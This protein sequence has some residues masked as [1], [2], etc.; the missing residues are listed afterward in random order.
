MKKSWVFIIFLI[1]ILVVVKLF[2]FPTPDKTAQSGKPG[3]GK[4]QKMSV[5]GYLVQPS[6]LDNL[7]RATGTLL[8]AEKVDIMPEVSGKITAIYFKEGAQVKQGE[9]LIKLYDKD[10]QLK[11][12]KLEDDHNVAAKREERLTKLL[13]VNGASQEE[14]EGVKNL[15]EGLNTEI[16]IVKSQIEKTEIRAPFSGTIGLRNVSE[17]AVISPGTKVAT[18]LDSRQ[19]KIDFSVPERYY[20]FIKKG[21]EIRCMIDGVGDTI[22]GSIY[23]LEPMVDLSTRSI[24]VRATVKN[25]RG[26]FLPGSFAK[27]VLSMENISDA[28]LVPTEAIIPV[29]KGQKVFVCKN[30]KAAEVMV[31]TGMRSDVNIQITDGL[32]AGDTLITTGI[33]SL[34]NDAPVN[35]NR[36]ITN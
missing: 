30:G 2:F 26:A 3:N 33:M 8:P 15:V 19:L 1:I 24:L 12:K 22:P 31:K 9:L 5:T 27:V 34:K 14:Y 35:I 28:L 23:A 10:L 36:L 25:D 13:S 7:I 17:G 16:D 20:P 21:Q 18:L 29:L 6:S 4:P 32:E 11:K